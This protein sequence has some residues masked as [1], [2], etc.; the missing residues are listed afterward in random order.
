MIRDALIKLG[1]NPVI[2]HGGISS[3]DRTNNRMAFQEDPSVTDFVAQIDSMGIGI[4][5]TAAEYVFYYS[6]SMS[7]IT[8]AQSEDRAHRIGQHKSVTYID[9]IMKGTIDVKIMK[10]LAKKEDL[11]RQ[12]M[13]GGLQQILED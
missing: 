1:R 3:E 13:S 5:L 6:N 8:R 12:I 2:A 4:T 7:Y 9:F 10:S 11:S